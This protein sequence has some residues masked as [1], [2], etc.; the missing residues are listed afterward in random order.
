MALP[1]YSQRRCRTEGEAF[2]PSLAKGSMRG[3]QL[4]CPG[5]PKYK[6]EAG[7]QGTQKTPE[8]QVTLKLWALWT[9]VQGSRLVR[10]MH[11][12]YLYG[13]VITVSEVPPRNVLGGFP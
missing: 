11:R 2:R 13:G 8:P 12:P 1:Q 5:K 4:F 7:R 6:A 10:F 3:T 9:R